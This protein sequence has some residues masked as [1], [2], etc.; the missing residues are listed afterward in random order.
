MQYVMDG[1]DGFC[2]GMILSRF[3]LAGGVPFKHTAEGDTAEEKLLH[4][5]A[6]LDE[7]SFVMA[8][9][10]DGVADRDIFSELG[11]EGIIKG[12]ENYDLNYTLS[13]FFFN[14][15]SGNQCRVLFVWKEYTE[16][17]MEECMEECME[18][19][20]REDEPAEY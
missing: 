11:T 5:A 10:E 3:S 2:G 1:W 6:N 13:P 14:P 15:N 20:E 18:E 4:I 19:P 17:Y 12:P 16:E 9:S 7:A 8:D